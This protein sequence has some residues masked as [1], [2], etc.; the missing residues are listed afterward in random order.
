MDDFMCDYSSNITYVRGEDEEDEEYGYGYGYDIS[1]E[2]EYASDAEGDVAESDSDS[3]SSYEFDISG[4]KVIE[5]DPVAYLKNVADAYHS[6]VTANKILAHTKSTKGN[7]EFA[8][9]YLKHSNTILKT[10][11][12][13]HPKV[14]M[15]YVKYVLKNDEIS[16]SDYLNGLECMKDAI[17]KYIEY[18]RETMSYEKYLKN[19]KDLMMFVREHGNEDD[20][21]MVVNGS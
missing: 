1:G 12:A 17:P 8:E 2:F 13:K 3:D 10:L 21:K 14:Y 15:N 19:M 7:V 6:V 16:Y 5:G 11:C 4:G 9:G 20:L 18:C